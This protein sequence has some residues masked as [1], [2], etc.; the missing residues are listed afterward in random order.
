MDMPTGL[1]V[2]VVPARGPGFGEA[3]GR[4]W[5]AHWPL[6]STCG[7]APSSAAIDR[8]RCARV[9]IDLGRL[10]I[11][12]YGPCAWAKVWWGR[13]RS[14]R[15]GSDDASSHR[16]LPRPTT[17][18]RF[19]DST[20]DAVQRFAVPEA[21]QLHQAPPRNRSVGR[22]VDR[23]ILF[24]THAQQRPRTLADAISIW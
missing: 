9:E 18:R 19:D 2:T 1:R 14:L 11:A 6:K 16:V 8:K 13:L 24:D 3:H 21:P 15:L 7:P 5:Q 17:V 4:G 10:P 23:S 22:S 12:P 20:M